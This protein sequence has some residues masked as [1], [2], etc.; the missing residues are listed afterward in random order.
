MTGLMRHMKYTLFSCRTN[1]KNEKS[2][3]DNF[4]AMCTL[5]IHKQQS[6]ATKA[7][8]GILKSCVLKPI[9]TDSIN[10]DILNNYAVLSL[11]KKAIAS[12]YMTRDASTVSA[13]TPLIKHLE[14]GLSDLQRSLCKQ[15]YQSFS[16]ETIWT[17]P[18]QLDTVNYLSED[19]RGIF[20]NLG[21][22]HDPIITAHKTNK[23]EFKQKLLSL[24]PFSNYIY[25]ADCFDFA[26]DSFNFCSNY[27]N[28]AGVF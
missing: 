15:S 7:L 13:R 26:I 2:I 19:L 8:V 25:G 18:T 28:F 5:G 27:L 4:V 12:W 24:L 16:N 6:P 1:Y 23:P 20:N 10:E 11:A 14:T 21:T 9:A 22:D 17:N 3:Y